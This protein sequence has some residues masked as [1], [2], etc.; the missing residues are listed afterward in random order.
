MGALFHDTMT[1]ADSGV[2][3]EG[4]LSSAGYV[5]GTQRATSMSEVGDPSQKFN[6]FLI[7]VS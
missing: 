5:T 6:D 1:V 3:F 4:N 2:A 7:I